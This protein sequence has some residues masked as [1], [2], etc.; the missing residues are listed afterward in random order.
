M[1][2]FSVLPPYHTKRQIHIKIKLL[3]SRV[4]SLGLCNPWTHQICQCHKTSVTGIC[5]YQWTLV[6]QSLDNLFYLP[7]NIPLW[8]IQQWYPSPPPSMSPIPT[9]AHRNI[10]TLTHTRPLTGANFHSHLKYHSFSMQLLIHRNSHSFISA[11]STPCCFLWYLWSFTS[12]GFWFSDF[13]HQHVCPIWCPSLELGGLSTSILL[14][15]LPPRFMS[16]Y[17]SCLC[18]DIIRSLLNVTSGP[19]LSKSQL[20]SSSLQTQWSILRVNF[21]V[22]NL[23]L[24]FLCGGLCYAPFCLC[25]FFFLYKTTLIWVPPIS[26]LFPSFLFFFPISETW[27]LPEV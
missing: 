17:D 9:N 27:V 16:F 13:K 24:D 15:N 14:F 26:D 1:I 18:F 25:L 10:H 3:L 19:V 2:W 7:L 8:F 11:F 12:S 6:L 23:S 4:L 21:L 5:R 20:W 22:V